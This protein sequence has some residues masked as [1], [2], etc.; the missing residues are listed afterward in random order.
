MSDAL[1][2]KQLAVRNGLTGEVTDD[3]WQWLWVDN[4]A[5]P[6][7]WPIGWVLEHEQQ[8][9][10]YIGNIPRRYVAHGR[11]VIAAC[12]RAFVVDLIFRRHALKLL[13]AFYKQN[14]A[15]VY[16]FTG[17]NPMAAP[18]YQL[19][20]ARPLPQANFNNTLYWIFSAAGLIASTVR[21]RGVPKLLAATVAH[22]VGPLLDLWQWLVCR[23]RMALPTGLS[24]SVLDPQ[25]IGP[26]FD[27]FWSRWC[28]DTLPQ[29]KAERSAE[30]LR[31]QFAHS[32]AAARQPVFLCIRQ[33]GTLM[34]YVVLTRW[35]STSVGLQRLMVADLVAVGNR[36]E[37]V[38]GLMRG[39]LSY[40]RST[41]VH[42][43]QCTGLPVEVR[44]SLAYLAPRRRTM[45]DVSFFYFPKAE[46]LVEWL[47]QPEHWYASMQDGDSLL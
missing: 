22:T 37:L 29:F 7:A 46:S 1:G 35:D 16:L 41:R 3:A 31:W 17:A 38:V 18:L 43:L 32:A 28:A 12:A 6:A 13:S 5:C 36:P 30:L 27:D 33:N 40:G 14:G 11:P 34:G 24:I 9:V 15:D 4:P 20:Q 26:E 47:A 21:K 45:S 2:V 23:N 42:L 19:A 8:L 39:A 10:G 25:D 44:Q